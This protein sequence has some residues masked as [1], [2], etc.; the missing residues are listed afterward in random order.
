MGNEETDDCDVSTGRRQQ[1]VAPRA[2]LAAPDQLSVALG[3]HPP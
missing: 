2:E 3:V 1:S